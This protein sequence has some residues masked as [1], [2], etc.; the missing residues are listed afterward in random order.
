MI[1][2]IEY[3]KADNPIIGQAVTN[4]GREMCSL[5]HK[6]GGPKEDLFIVLRLV[7]NRIENKNVIYEF[8]LIERVGNFSNEEVQKEFASLI[9]SD[10]CLESVTVTFR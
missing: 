5:I 3:P 2:R 1:I 9:E 6:T 8:E 7:D 10:L 4:V